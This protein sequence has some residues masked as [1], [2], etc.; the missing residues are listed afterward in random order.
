MVPAT[1]ALCGMASLPMFET[2]VVR[3]WRA[4]ELVPSA[5]PQ[6]APCD[7]K[8]HRGSSSSERNVRSSTAATPNS[9]R[10]RKWFAGGGPV[11][12]LEM[13]GRHASGCLCL[14]A[15]ARP[16]QPG[17]R[18]IAHRSLFSLRPL[19]LSSPRRRVRAGIHGCMSTR[20]TITYRNTATAT[21]I[22]TS[23][24]LAS[25]NQAIIAAL[26]ERGGFLGRAGRCKKKPRR[27]GAKLGIAKARHASG[28]PAV[29]NLSRAQAIVDMGRSAPAWHASG[30][31]LGED[32]GIASY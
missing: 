14:T 18:P 30:Q 31:L 21:P 17:M 28:A 15:T 25:D 6:S 19:W 13:P 8:A 11:E 22:P 32:I 29:G 12:C 3:Q 24:S 5:I 10:Q 23:S 2:N 20:R 7:E 27:S 1:A 26:R 4:R 16:Q 9:S